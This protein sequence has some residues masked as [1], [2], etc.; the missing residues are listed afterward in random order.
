M[1]NVNESH[2]KPATL[3]TNVEIPS[4]SLQTKLENENII[5]IFDDHDK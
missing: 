4:P 1:E 2:D 5:E 3:A